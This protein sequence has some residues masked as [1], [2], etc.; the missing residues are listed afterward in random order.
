ML[1]PPSAGRA[2]MRANASK[3]EAARRSL[4]KELRDPATLQGVAVELLAAALVRSRALRAERRDDCQERQAALAALQ[5]VR[6]LVVK[7]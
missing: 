5:V 2:L 4:E 3:D 7:P 1:A 6:T